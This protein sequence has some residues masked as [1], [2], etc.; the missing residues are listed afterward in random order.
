[1]EAAPP[2]SYAFVILCWSVAPRF[3]PS[4]PPRRSSD[5]D[6][7]ARR[8]AVGAHVLLA[9]AR[10]AAVV[11]GDRHRGMSGRSEEHTSEFQSLRHL[12][13][14]LLLEKK[15][16]TDTAETTSARIRHFVRH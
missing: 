1:M 4:F 2:A 6:L 3:L 12:V 11:A 7:D 14:R 8:R 15:N 13:C 16:S 5:L 9:P 10:H